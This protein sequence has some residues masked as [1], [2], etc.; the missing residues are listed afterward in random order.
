[1][2]KDVRK[3]AVVKLGRRRSRW[4]TGLRWFGAIAF[5]AVLVVPVFFVAFDLYVSSWKSL[6]EI[7]NCGFDRLN[8]AR[9]DYGADDL[10]GEAASF[11]GWFP[12]LDVYSILFE[13]PGESA[14]RYRAAA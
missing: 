5:L 12:R 11:F 10:C 6:A 13:L 1:M 14:G 4:R 3:L 7:G 2:P 9:S 8:R